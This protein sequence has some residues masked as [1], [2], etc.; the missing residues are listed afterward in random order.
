MNILMSSCLDMLIIRFLGRL[1]PPPHPEG[2]ID[3]F[4]SRDLAILLGFVGVAGIGWIE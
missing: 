3:S 2:I 4:R 1:V